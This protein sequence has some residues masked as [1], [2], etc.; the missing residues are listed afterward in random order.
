MEVFKYRLYNVYPR[1]YQVYENE[2][3]TTVI[4]RVL[5]EFKDNAEGERVAALFAASPKMRD[6]LTDIKNSLEAWWEYHKIRYNNLGEEQDRNAMT[7]YQN[8]I[9]KAKEALP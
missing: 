4:K 5:A 9:N 3:N 2:P 8:L 1:I 6:T 7:N